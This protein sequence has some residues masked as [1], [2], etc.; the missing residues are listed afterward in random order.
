MPAYIT[1]D[2][3][4]KITASADWP[5]PGSS[6]CLCEII[7]YPDGQLYRSDALPPVYAVSGSS[8]QQVGGECPNGGVLMSGLRPDDVKDADGVITATWVA[9]DD[10]EWQMVPT[11]TLETVKADKL[12]EI[13]A[14]T[15]AAILAG[16]DYTVNDVLYHFSYDS[17]DQQNFVDTAS[18]C[19]LKLQGIEELPDSITWNAYTVPDK[20]L[21]RLTFDAAGFITLYT[22]GAMVHKNTA[23][24][25]GG[26][27]KEAVK[28]ATTFEEVEAV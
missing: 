3:N 22:A 9:G 27:R 28:T 8:D 6:P 12:E 23:L 4:G 21:V 2:K 13:D 1:T 26:I 25:V 15:S 10:G 14:E 24:Q 16:F 7:R 18:V 20:V 5:F 11:V 19:L 17:F